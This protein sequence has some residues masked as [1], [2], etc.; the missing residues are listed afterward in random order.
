MRR[1]SGGFAPRCGRAAGP[2]RGRGE[3]ARM[4]RSALIAGLAAT[5]GLATLPP[6]AR[7][8]RRPDVVLSAE[9]SSWEVR[10]GLISRTRSYGGMVPGKL[11]RMREGERV[12][13]ELRNRTRE[14]QTI[15]WHGLVVPDTVD[16]LRTPAVAPGASRLYEFTATPAGTRLYHSVQGGGMFTGLCGPLIVDARDERGNYDREE[17]LLLHEFDPQ[18]PTRGSMMDE[19]PPGSPALSAPAMGMDGMN[20]M[21][22]MSGMGDMGGLLMYDATYAAYA[23]NGKALG[24]GEPLRVKRGERVR[25]RIINASATITHRLALPGHRFLVTHL[26][27]NA[28]PSPR[29]VDAVELG[30]GERVDA[31][32]TMETP[33]IWILGSTVQEARS[34]GLGIVVAYAGE[35]GE[36]QWREAAREPFRYT[37]FGSAAAAG[38]HVEGVYDLVLRQSPEGHNAWSING[39]RYPRTL[40]IYVRQGKTFLLRFSNLSMMEHPM[41]VLG[42]GFELAMVDGAP[43]S[44]IRKDTVVVR[45]MMGRVDVLFHA[46]NPDGGAYLLMCHNW[47]HMEGGMACA[48]EYV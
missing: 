9:E 42:N 35:R 45:P 7:A 23:I 32:V 6:P 17:V 2:W 20:S 34:N 27:G 12:L 1:G 16:G 31:L 41:H 28:V 24:A 22:T 25:L 18:I 5:G 19:R 36:P 21:G 48:V 40:P 44:G 14:A 4:N 30:P 38:A 3:S 39:R 13:V 43:T 46:D 8:G 26:D 37:D 47:Q 15:S 29:S 33:G 10:P 11:L